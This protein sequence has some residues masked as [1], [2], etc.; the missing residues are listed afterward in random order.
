MRETVVKFVAPKPILKVPILEAY[1]D[2]LSTQQRD[3]TDLFQ[4][5]QSLAFN[6]N[7]SK[8]EKPT[9]TVPDVYAE[10]NENGIEFYTSNNPLMKMSSYNIMHIQHEHL[11]IARDMEGE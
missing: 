11:K 1:L 7:A 6:P 5:H 4:L 9:F 10:I 8:E 3:K 2:S